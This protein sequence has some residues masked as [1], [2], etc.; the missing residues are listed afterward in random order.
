VEPDELASFTDEEPPTGRYVVVFSDDVRGKEGA[1]TGAL[2]SVT[3]VSS[4]ASSSDF[5]DGA[6]DVEQVEDADATVFTELGVAVVT[7]D[8]DRVASLTAVAAED[9]RIEAIEPELTMHALTQP[10]TVPLEY[11]RGFR[12]GASDLYERANGGNGAAVAD[13]TVVAPQFVDTPTFTWG[14]QATRVFTSTKSGLGVPVAIL[15]TGFDLRHPDFVGRRITATS[16]VPGQPVQDGHGHGT[17]V[18]GTS[19][20]PARPPGGHRRYG[21]A[22]GDNIF[23]GKVLSNQGSGLDR[24]ILAGINWAVANRCRV[25]SMSLGAD[26]RTVS[27][28]YEIV[29]RRAMAAG[30]LIIAAASNN[31]DRANGNFG[32]VG[33]P[34][35]SPSVMAVAALDSQLRIANFSARS[36]PVLGGQIDIVAP[37]VAVDSSWSL[38]SSMPQRYRIINGTSMATP[39]VSGI[40]AQWSA[41]RAV[42]GAALWALLITTAQR[43]PIPSADGGAGLVQAPQ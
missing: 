7:A 25:I 6:V 35:N 43:L 17:H 22:Y 9:A 30:S 1:L 5:A 20:G 18:A 26:V 14:L 32:F 11:L 2:R 42:T 3:G 38:S 19:S 27:Q 21:V 13:G 37:G 36:S 28:V 29:G 16:F 23:V 39:H 24:Y 10:S 15:D 40:A 4:V 41:A 8:Q 12:D 31:A 33:V 34:A